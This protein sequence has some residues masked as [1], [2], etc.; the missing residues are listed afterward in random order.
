MRDLPEGAKL[1]SL[2]RDVL[3]DELL[4]LL[5][6]ER[7][8][9]ALLVANCLA[10][11]ERE[12]MLG[13]APAAAREVAKLYRAESVSSSA[14]AGAAPP[15]DCHAAAKPESDAPPALLGDQS[16]LWRRF[17]R[18]LRNGAFEDSAERER[19][20]R[21]ILWRLTLAKLRLANP[22]FLNANG[23]A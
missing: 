17:A 7:R 22:K 23:I 10:I 20:A 9:D 18:D 19:Q 14:E 4:P 5:P 8:I 1:L 12:A 13:A 3:L 21:A 15:A 16:E 11:A 6:A 2:A